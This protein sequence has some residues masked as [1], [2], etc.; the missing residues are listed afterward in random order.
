MT[1][2][3]NHKSWHFLSRHWQHAF[4]ARAA[5]SVTE[6][7]CL[8]YVAMTRP[9]QALHL[10][11]QPV[12]KAAFDARTPAALIFHALGLESDPTVGGSTLFEVGD[13][14]WMINR[15]DQPAPTPNGQTPTVEIQFQ[16]M[17]PV[18]RRNRGG[19]Q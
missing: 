3:L 6:A 13:E 7:L 19:T 8:L 11:I 5:A 9:R 14:D 12:K 16:P 10:V 2:Y 15:D 17:P 18:P 4:G 1:R